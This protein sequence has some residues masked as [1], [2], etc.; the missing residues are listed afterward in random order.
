MM[1][2]THDQPRDAS[3][4]SSDTDNPQQSDAG[5]PPADQPAPG[6]PGPGQPPGGAAGPNWQW[7][8]PV[9]RLIMAEPNL[10]TRGLTTLV[11]LL[12]VS[13]FFFW[14]VIPALF[15]AAEVPWRMV[16]L[17][18]SPVALF[19]GYLLWR[20][21]DTPSE[22]RA[23]VFEPDHV[24]LPVSHNSRREKRVAY[25]DIEGIMTMQRGASQSVLVDVDGSTIA[26]R[27]DQFERPESLAVLQQELMRR[28]RALPE[29]DQVIGRMR[30]RQKLARIASSK[31]ATWTKIILGVL[32]GYFALELATGVL[33]DPFGLIDLGANAP[34]LIDQGQYFRLIAANFLHA[35]WIHLILNGI[36]LFFLGLAIEKLMGSWRLVLIY[37]LGA[38]GGSL[39]SYLAGPGAM[40]VG[41][42]T[43]IF[44]LF[45]AFL[46]V[47]V[48][49]WHQLMPPFRQSIN[50][51]VFIIG[52]N[53]ALPVVVPAIDYVA[54]LAGFGVGFVAA[55][56]LLWPMDE[57][58]PGARPSLAVRAATVGLAAVF[59]A[60]LAQAG[61]YALDPPQE[62]R[63]AVYRAMQ[64]DV[65]ED[66][67]SADRVNELAW[68]T[69]T[70]EEADAERLEQAREA[71][72]EVLDE[73]PDRFEI[74]D[75]LATVN[76]R[77]AMKSTGDERL[78]YVREAIAIEV[79][80]LDEAP[81]GPEVFG[82]G[83]ATYAS[84]LA[85]FL[86]YHREV[87][88]PL[89]DGGVLEK[90]PE[91]NFDR[92]AGE[93]RI[94]ASEAPDADTAVY[95]VARTEGRIVGL[96]RTC[97]P[98]DEM[99]QSVAA[100]SQL[101]GAAGEELSLQVGL[102]TGQTACPDRAQFWP[103][104]DEIAELP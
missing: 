32:A 92:E 66:D 103:M 10:W 55:Y 22:R 85:R 58:R 14:D 60:G 16:L 45:G 86:D 41:S 1:D 39:G 83:K 43:A 82:G 99:G 29:A 73:N 27:A 80:I 48:R 18:V 93:L 13:G 57:P 37:L 24:V 96:A 61:V 95:A 76:Y 54:H 87:D 5:A 70:N 28:I 25:G 63:D 72:A 21:W 2:E 94:V 77:L 46:A 68:M 23:V 100:P 8:G 64:E 47:H 56:G 36:G 49:F 102:V 98:A 65:G 69:A 97:L 88:G 101:E 75:T 35:G 51:W 78:E 17:A 20:W 34:E 4:P 84:Q 19:I 26:Y 11:V 33:D 15:Q 71:T 9:E 59:V 79:R 52:I 38:L 90:A 74:W 91:I 6:E 3:E 42:S 40:S 30:E 62:D 50:W 44:G 67:A 7:R 12:A 104:S 89:I 81:G 53:A 31:P